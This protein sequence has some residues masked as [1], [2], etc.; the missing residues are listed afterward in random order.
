MTTFFLRT[1][2]LVLFVQGAQAKDL[3]S[4]TAVGDIMMGTTYPA[5][6]LPENGGRD[7]FKPAAQWI[8]ASD[9]R[10]GNFEGTFFDGP[11]QSDGKS[12]GPNRYLFRTPP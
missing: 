9:I 8:D 4:I 12:A 11:P 10:F 3:I 1:L 7:L 5:N 6:A 2:V